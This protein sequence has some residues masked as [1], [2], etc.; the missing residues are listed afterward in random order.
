MR[1]K[2]VLITGA[3]NGIGRAAA[4]GLAALGA[5]LCIVG[6]DATKTEQ[7]AAQLR[8]QHTTDVEVLLADL[9]SQAAVHQLADQVLERYERLDVLVNNAGGFFETRRTTVDGF[10]YTFALNHLGYVTL[11][12]RL[13]DLL[14]ASTP[15]RI[16]NVSSEA[17]ATGR[18]QFDDLQFSRRYSGFAAYSQSKLANV[19][20]TYALARRLVG[21]GVTV[22]ALHPGV[23]R[24]GFGSESRNPLFRLAFQAIKQFG[25][26][27][28]QGADT[29]IYLASNPDIA[30][31]SGQ[32]FVRRTPKRSSALS[33]DQAAQERLWALSES[34]TGRAAANKSESR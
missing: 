9:S 21:S 22:N 8:T 10:E 20:F 32:Y 5:S 1:D 29:V 34:L 25:I 23:V 24:S 28:E 26:S 4:T 16:I 33:Y 11:T 30:T 7:V 19:M 31:A 27:P 2:R 15:A 3:T 17:Q 14:R 6:R 13:L 12:A 18:I